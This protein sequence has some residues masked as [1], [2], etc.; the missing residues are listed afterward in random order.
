MVQTFNVYCNLFIYF[1]YFLYMYP[2]NYGT[3]DMIPKILV[4][5]LAEEQRNITGSS[6]KE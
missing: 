4:R 6:P 5:N 3:A 2:N 1:T